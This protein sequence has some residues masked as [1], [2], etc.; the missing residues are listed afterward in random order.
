MDNRDI[1]GHIFSNLDD[2]SLRTLYVHGFRDNIR[3][4]LSHSTFW[5]T[6]VLKL[7]NTIA[8]PRD[9]DWKRVYYA[10]VSASGVVDHVGPWKYGLDYLPSLE[11]IVT[12]YNLPNWIDDP[13]A[14]HDVWEDVSSPEVLAY[15][16]DNGLLLVGAGC[17]MSKYGLSMAASM[18]RWDMIETILELIDDVLQQAAIADAIYYAVTNSH[19]KSLEILLAKISNTTPINHQIFTIAATSGTLEL[20]RV[21]LRRY[22]PG[23]WA[24]MIQAALQHDNAASLEAII[25][26]KKPTTE[27]DLVSLFS[28]ALR[29]KKIGI[30]TMLVRL[31]PTSMGRHSY[32]SLL[33]SVIKLPISP[34]QITLATEL[35]AHISSAA[36]INQALKLAVARSNLELVKILL[37]I[38][39]MKLMNPSELISISKSEALTDILLRDTRIQIES[40]N[41]D[42]IEG[43]L[44][45]SSISTPAL[46]A[47]I[48]GESLHSQLIFAMTLLKLSSVDLMDWM[49]DKHDER[50]SL[51]ATQLLSNEPTP[52]HL[53]PTRTLIEYLL[54]T[55]VT[56]EDSL[57]K[58]EDV[59]ESHAVIELSRQLISVHLATSK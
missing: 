1:L 6:R 7:D 12:M 4:L 57:D 37:S 40:L 20:S 46:Y 53:V 35:L 9:T 51:V 13:S 24:S 2:A 30:I 59:G 26:A 54:Y 21:L 45:R 55:N 44:T 36:K 38:P 50:F 14:M 56:L 42:A 5:E 49:I 33:M 48:Q 11:A 34:S 15:L 39:R 52:S 17:Y 28:S 29:D 32:A 43:I 16:I 10:L 41:K 22:I 25:E 8:L 47:L 23:D 3:T 18:N 19:L 27:A 31:H 58:L